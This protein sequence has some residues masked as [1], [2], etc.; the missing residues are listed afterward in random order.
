MEYSN[1]GNYTNN[2]QYL[3]NYIQFENVNF[4]GNTKSILYHQ[5]P[6]KPNT[7]NIH[8]ISV[9]KLFILLPRCYSVMHIWVGFMVWVLWF[10]FGFILFL[11]CFCVFLKCNVV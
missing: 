3:N 8:V 7:I 5:Y 2:N 6:N 4:T 11:I 9:C 10:G 1:T